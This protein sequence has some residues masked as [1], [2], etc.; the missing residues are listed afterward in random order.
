MPDAVACLVTF[1]FSSQ[2][3]TGHFDA[4][5]NLRAT[6]PADTM[7]ALLTSWHNFANADAKTTSSLPN[8]HVIS[9]DGD[10]SKVVS[11]TFDAVKYL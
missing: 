7:A 3:S 9:V 6:D 5:S 10:R 2:R 8:F 1:R 11:I 4:R